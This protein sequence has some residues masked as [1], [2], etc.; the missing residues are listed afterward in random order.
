MLLHAFLAFV[1]SSVQPVAI[2]LSSLDVKFARQD[3]GEARVDRSVDGRPLSIGGRSFARGL[4]THATGEFELA[5]APGTSRFHAFVGVDDEVG[6]KGSV[7]F[8]VLGDGKELFA[9]GVRR[10]GDPAVEVDVSLAGV[11]A[12]ALVVQDGGD[13]IDYDHADWADASFT[14]AGAPPK[15]I[16]PPVE[17]A[18]VLTPP[19][20]AAPR[21]TGPR[22]VGVR[23]GHPLLHTVTAMGERPR[24]FA[25]QGLPA[26]LA[27]DVATG[28]ITGALAAAGSHRVRVTVTN[29]KGSDS[30]E[31]RIECGERIA[32]TPPLGWNSWNAFACEVDAAKVR[33]AADALVS[34]GLADH[35]WSYVNVDDCWQ[36]E[37]DARGAIV[38][39]ARFGDM[40]ALAEYVHGKGLKFGLY[41]SPGPKTCAGYAGSWQHEEQDAA[42]WAA[43]GV[44]Y[45]KHDWCSYDGIAK[46]HGL[47]EL[48][49][50]YRVMRAAL[51]HAPRDIV[52]SLCQYGMGD[53]WTW[54]ADVGGNSW[55]TTG[56]IVDTW[57]SVASI[58]FAEAG[59]ER[60]AG[61]GHW[62]DPDMLVVG[63]VGWG[64]PHPTRLTPNEQYAHISL[65]CLLSAPLLIGCD[66]AEL[67]PFT[68][69]LLTND[70]VL[71]VDQDP[72]G[73]P[74][75]RVAKDG[76]AEVWAKP[77][78]DGSL[79]VGLF[80]RGP[81]ARTVVAEW[82]ALG[83][84][85]PR[86]VVDLWRQASAG[87]VDAR[88]AAEVPRHGVVL[89]R[90]AP[91]PPPPGGR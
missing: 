80:N 2:P 83:L 35:G 66:L 62:N 68:L 51:D 58:G 3:W 72:L 13:G 22:V 54:G 8:R 1:P 49:K 10:G 14:C 37:R 77:L 52:Y 6:E 89:V 61:P 18:V 85:G 9:S 56:D 29:A 26:G 67:D 47:V 76:D 69:N 16:A 63:R 32:L 45:V 11:K 50:P 87:V 74:A 19:A 34:S 81:R 71:D 38:P 90:L 75:A 27:L 31:L 64:K 82:K 84:D 42:T 20:P 88:F 30:R 24:T 91:T 43:W 79:A 7:E 23:P 86:E 44:D 17:E 46:D 53:V 55:R 12:L 28:R 39:N 15:P 4:G 25:A 70:A 73:K 59:H 78:F 48:Q 36:A 60:F 40:A 33:A 21:L 57:S 41:S 65:W 5:L